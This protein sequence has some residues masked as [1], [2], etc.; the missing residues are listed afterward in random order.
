MGFWDSLT[1][2]YQPSTYGLGDAAKRKELPKP[3]LLQTPAQESAG[4][5]L[6]SYLDAYG[7]DT[8]TAQGAPYR[9]YDQP[10]VAGLQPT[11]RMGQDILSGYATS[12]LS[13]LTELSER[14]ITRTLEGAFDPM[15]SDYYKS[16]RDILG[17]EGEDQIEALRRSQQLRGAF[18]STGGLR[19]EGRLREGIQSRIGQVLG[20]L[21]QTEGARRF[22]AL[23][24][25]QTAGANRE[26]APVRRLEAIQEYGA[27]PR[28]IDQAGLSAAYQEFQRQR[29]AEQGVVGTA[30]NAVGTPEYS[31]KMYEP[32]AIEQ[33]IQ[34]FGGV[35]QT[36]APFV[37]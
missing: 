18:S 20:E 7:G 19:E 36:A 6:Q 32:S 3:D 4:S 23:P 14:E 12:G 26:L 29:E 34:L 5:T 1:K 30:L 13:P 10:L 9:A 11:E 27:L 15:T 37:M 22:A 8:L 25:A 35:A 21:A 31:R 16:T 33:L 2:F 24:L 17:R 28:Q